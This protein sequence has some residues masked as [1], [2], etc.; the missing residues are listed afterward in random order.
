[1]V[2]GA[3]EPATSPFGLCNPSP[4]D[5]A[6]A[7][8]VSFGGYSVVI[9]RGFVRR[10]RAADVL[11]YESGQQQL[12]ILATNDPHLF[13]TTGGTPTS[14]RTI[15]TCGATIAGVPAEVALLSVH[16]PP[17]LV[18]DLRAGGRF[19]VAARFREAAHG[20]DLV[21]YVGA[22]DRR[23]VEANAGFLWTVKFERRANPPEL[24]L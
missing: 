23:T 21:V 22:V 9:P 24:R 11:L 4:V 15:E 7:A 17:E 10:G 5:T 1:V 16:M 13:A 18:G 14:Q 6:R 19:V 12:G 2:A 3:A 20:R 8:R